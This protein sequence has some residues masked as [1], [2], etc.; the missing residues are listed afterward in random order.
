MHIN[1]PGES[2]NGDI[3]NDG[4]FNRA[5]S[6]IS[7]KYNVDILIHSDYDRKAGGTGPDEKQR[8]Q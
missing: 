4:L 6:Q 7:E 8:F 3:V 1:L 2:L 5:T